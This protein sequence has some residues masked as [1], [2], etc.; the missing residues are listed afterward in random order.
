M[1]DSRSDAGEAEMLLSFLRAELDSPTEADRL[2]ETL[3]ELKV[4]PDIL[5]DPDIADDAENQLRRDVFMAYR[6]YEPV[7]EGLRF[8]EVSWCWVAVTEH[9]LRT[10][11]FT[12]RHHYEATYGTRLVGEIV[13]LRDRTSEGPA[14]GVLERIRWGESLEPPILL[15]GP[16][17]ERMVVLEGHNRVLSYLKDPEAVGFPVRAL[18][19]VSSRISEWCE[20]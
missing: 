8:D 3:R 18:L 7:F 1:P 19:G 16:D 14:G 15:T 5:R 17:M 6:G 12:C 20:W 9:D 10:R 13:E 11:T 2:R 4:H